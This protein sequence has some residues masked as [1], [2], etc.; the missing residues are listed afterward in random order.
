VVASLQSSLDGIGRQ[1]QQR[2]N[3]QAPGFE[4]ATLTDSRDAVETA[5]AELARLDDQYQQVAAIAQNYAPG[6]CRVADYAPNIAAFTRKWRATHEKPP[7]NNPHENDDPKI[8]EGACMLSLAQ[9]N[10]LKKDAQ[11]TEGSGIVIEESEVYVQGEAVVIR[12]K[13]Q[14]LRNSP[15]LKPRITVTGGIMSKIVDLGYERLNPP[16]STTFQLQLECFTVEAYNR[17]MNKI[18][19]HQLLLIF[20]EPNGSERKVIQPI[21]IRAGSQ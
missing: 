12:G 10:Q 16:L 14:N 19:D 13:L 18:P 3:N 17:S 7:V 20:Q 2:L 21:G 8:N 4:T 9:H 5:S 11:S 1:I 15:I 6:E